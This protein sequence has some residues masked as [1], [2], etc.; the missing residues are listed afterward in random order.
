MTIQLRLNVDQVA[1]A[2]QLLSP[3][4]KRI[5]QQRMPQLLHS[6]DGLDDLD[7]LGWLR[8]SESAFDFWNNPQEDIYNDLIPEVEGIRS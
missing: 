4:E 6:E 3:D 2:I 7:R 5:L 1:I 8:A